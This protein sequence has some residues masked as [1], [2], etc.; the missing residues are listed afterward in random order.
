M[1]KLIINNRYGIVPNDL[2][3]NPEISFKAKGL[4]AYIQSK[5][6]NWNFSAKNIATQTKES[7]DG[8]RTGLVE[9][10]RHGYLVRTKFNKENGLLDIEYTLYSEPIK[11]TTDKPLTG[12]PTTG[13]PTTIVR[14]KSSKKDIS[15]KESSYVLSIFEINETTLS[16]QEK[17]LLKKWV[18]YKYHVKKEVYETVGFIEKF[19]KQ[20]KE[21]GFIAVQNAI[22]DSI[23]NEY[24]G[25]FPKNDKTPI[26][27]NIFKPEPNKQ[28]NP[29]ELIKDRITYVYK[30]SELVQMGSEKAKQLF[31]YIEK[32]T[33]KEFMNQA[34]KNFYLYYY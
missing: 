27:S 33:P 19:I 2:L 34:E 23:Y 30:D 18:N 4:F 13:N 14:K 11:P 15:K 29:L 17:E 26:K 20:I 5:P 9:L 7:I 3:N 1:A 24:K 28:P 10:E 12:N 21:F 16:D 6:D 22:Q 8:V 31:W 32:K 25:Y